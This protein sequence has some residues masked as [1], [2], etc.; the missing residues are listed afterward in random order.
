VCTVV[1]DGITEIA[2]EIKQTPETILSSLGLAFHQV[3]NY[4]PELLA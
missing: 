3:N 4:E 1:L 2:S